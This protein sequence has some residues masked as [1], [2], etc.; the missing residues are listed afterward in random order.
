MIDMEPKSTFGLYSACTIQMLNGFGLQMLSIR[1]SRNKVLRFSAQSLIA[2]G[3]ILLPSSIFY[4]FLIRDT[5]LLEP[6][7]LTLELS[8]VGGLSTF[9]AWI[10]T[11]LN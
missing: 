5:I 4:R 7:E 8:K 11:I 2:V 3:A 9:I 1:E 6:G 10:I